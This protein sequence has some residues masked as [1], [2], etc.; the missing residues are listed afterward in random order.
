MSDV[1]MIPKARLDAEVARRHALEAKLETAT[2][3]LSAMEAQLETATKQAKD[4]T[5]RAET[6]EAGHVDTGPLNGRIKELEAALATSESARKE[7][8]A[9]L[10]SGITDVDLLRFEHSRLGEDAPPLLDWVTAIKA[11]RDAA[12]ATLRG[13]LPEP[14]QAESTEQPE[15][16]GTAAAGGERSPVQSG[17]DGSTSLGGVRSINEQ[18]R[19][20]PAGDPRRRELVRQLHQRDSGG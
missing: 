2:D 5:K 9:I 13:F 3:K 6:A 15:R 4:A 14:A 7:D 19:R 17:G 11:D 10:A 16:R 12:P 20:L 18:L 1:E 8:A